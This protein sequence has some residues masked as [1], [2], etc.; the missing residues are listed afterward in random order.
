MKA[1]FIGFSSMAIAQ[2]T[3]EIG[4]YQVAH[5]TLTNQKGMVV[6]L[7]NWGA[8]LVDVCTPDRDGFVQ[9]VT[10][11]HRDWDAYEA[12]APFLGSTIGRV[13]GRI[14][15]GHFRLAGQAYQLPTQ[16]AF[17]NHH[18]HGGAGAMS[19]QIWQVESVNDVDNAVT[20]FYRSL[21]GENGYPSQ[22]DLRVTYSLSDNSEL[23]IRYESSNTEATLCNPTN[24]AYFN[25]SGNTSRTVHEHQLQV[26]ADEVCEMSE[27]L[28]VTGGVWPVSGTDFDFR[29]L[30]PLR[31]ALS[32]QDPRLRLAAGIDHYFV[33]KD[34][35]SAEPSVTLHDA[36][37][38]RRLRV[39]TDRPCVVL[40]AH[41]YSAGELLR[42]GVVGVA[43]DALC[44][45]T[46]LLP[47]II[48]SDGDHPAAQYPTN[49][50]VTSTVFGFDVV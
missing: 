40:Y 36:I 4:A 20:F 50:A 32:S 34:M 19:Q 22:L 21:A 42:H 7:M 24:H 46:Q 3:V 17:G 28:L 49:L 47:H 23:T 6:E 12:N 11:A 5:L 45:E 14:P 16:A 2:K 18:L 33:L 25:L 13:A 41:N 1:F 38:G 48:G 15:H 8:T 10:L 9:S 44:I 43:H 30:K 26:A 27:A 39:W 37:S 29:D 35:A 31:V